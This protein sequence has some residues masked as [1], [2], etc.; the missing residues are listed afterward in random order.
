MKIGASLLI[1]TVCLPYLVRY[2]DAIG[3]PISRP[4]GRV[5]IYG[6]GPVSRS[7]TYS[8]LLLFLFLPLLFGF[9]SVA[10]GTDTVILAEDARTRLTNLLIRR[11]TL[12]GAEL[13]AYKEQVAFCAA[14]NKDQAGCALLGATCVWVC[15]CTVGLCLVA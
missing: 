8:P 6:Y 3:F 15:G 10:G 14:A 13:A 12:T 1:L 4:Y 2:C 11:S 9:G 5:G 7:G